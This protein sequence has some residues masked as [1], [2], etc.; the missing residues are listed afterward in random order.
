[1]EHKG[2]SGLIV[3][4]KKFDSYYCPALITQE[5]S[6]TTVNM[7]LYLEKGDLQHKMNVSQGH[8]IGQWCH[9]GIDSTN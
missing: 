9:T 2:L 7:T 5:N 4:Y 1:M 6:D 8:E 3:L